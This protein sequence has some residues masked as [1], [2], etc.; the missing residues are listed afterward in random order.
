MRPPR[1]PLSPWIVLLIVSLVLLAR[2]PFFGM[3]AHR[4][5]AYGMAEWTWAL[6]ERGPTRFYDLALEVAPDHLPGDLW[7]LW[8]MGAPLHAL[9]PGF[10]F[11]A[12][13]YTLMLKTVA[14]LAD[15][16]IAL[17]LLAIGCKL[18]KPTLGTG[19][20]VAFAL[21]PAAIIISAVWGQWDALSVAAI[22]VALY[23]LLGGRWTLAAVC[24]V[25][26]CLVKPQLGIILPG[27]LIY[28]SRTSLVGFVWRDW[29]WRKLLA[30]AAA[31][32]ATFYA[33]CLPFGVS[34]FGL[35]TAWSIGDRLAFAA[36]RY[37]STTLGA[38]NLWL[39]PIGREVAP[40]DSDYLV[41]S[42]TYREVSICLLVL[43]CG[44][45]W[46]G[47]GRLPDPR[48]ALLWSS[49]V[50]TL[51]VFLFATRVHERYLFPAMALSFLLVLVQRRAWW[52]P[53]A[54]SLTLFL[55]VW[56]SLAWEWVPGGTTFG[57]SRDLIVRVLALVN[58]LAFGG[59]LKLGWDHRSRQAPPVEVP[60]SRLSPS[61]MQGDAV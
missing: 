4:Y 37:Q 15:L 32:V 33:L 19:L 2:L 22:V 16:A 9:D 41:G 58:L 36:D 56:S 52:I 11:Y 34:L 43:A 31:G 51:G 46:W 60:S 10:D 40:L 39:L 26:A 8:L 12:H 50:T 35:F 3:A 7:I 42:L 49:V 38:F 24:A 29:P 21:N 25:F 28:L 48:A 1:P 23:A 20:A 6:A 59:V 53:A 61:S 44:I 14:L 27:M 47:A 45:A 57:V 17:G 5:D 13:P 30:A 55:S 54:L 18:G